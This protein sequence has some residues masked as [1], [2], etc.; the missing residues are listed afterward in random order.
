MS[1]KKKVTDRK[2]I[3][4]NEVSN[5]SKNYGVPESEI[6][7]ARIESG[8]PRS[9]RKVFAVLV[10]AGFVMLTRYMKKKAEPAP[11][12]PTDSIETPGLLDTGV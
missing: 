11:A 4:N 6:E 8:H 10:A 3:A 9:K 1:H 5:L 12:A 7:A 2:L